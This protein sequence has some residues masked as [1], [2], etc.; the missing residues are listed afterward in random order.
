MY[1]AVDVGRS[2]PP[3]RRI[4]LGAIPGRRTTRPD[5][6][7][8]TSRSGNDLVEQQTGIGARRHEIPICVEFHQPSLAICRR[9]PRAR[10]STGFTSGH[11]S[12]PQVVDVMERIKSRTRTQGAKGA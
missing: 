7:D 2:M 11:A 12:W 5:F 1:R 9:I 4:A 3:S 10:R 6:T 8:G